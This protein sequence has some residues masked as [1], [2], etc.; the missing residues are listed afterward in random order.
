[1]ETSSKYA[2]RGALFGLVAA[3]STG[4]GQT[5]F[6]GLFGAE[7]RAEFAL[8]DASLGLMYGVATL[9]A[10]SMMFW[11]GGLAD[12][13][14]LSRAVTLSVLL[15]AGGALLVATAHAAAALI[16][17]L[18][19]LRLGGQG[20]TGHF[21]IVAAARYA[22]GARRGRGVA[23]ASLGF[24]L[25]EALYPILVVAALGIWDWRTV[26]LIVALVL[27]I[28]FVP[29]LRSIARPLPL[30]AAAPAASGPAVVD[31]TRGALLRSPTFL[32]AL[33]VVL[34]SPLLATAV[35]FH[36]AALGERLGW[37]ASSVA[38]AFMLF[39]ACQAGATIVSGRLIDIIGARALMRYYL[40]PLAL[41][42]MSL[43]TFAPATALWMLFAGIGF[44]AGANSVVA[45]A[46]WV[47]LFGSGQLGMIRG[48]YA[49]LMVISTAVSPA[50]LGALLSAD[51]SLT[52]I[53]VPAIAY[54]VIVPWLLA[55]MTRPA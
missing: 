31:W 35:F 34:V 15:V 11:L 18:F 12:R 32:G 50:I 42:L 55:P 28:I 22:S 25:S 21:A 52:A 30:P 46:V 13:L 4:A 48:V 29:V 16:V 2:R 39:A 33:G 27:A 19:L 37:S 7:F 17:G 5:F 14:A 20:L 44:T 9:A 43:F 53:F 51:F 24:I 3:A 10:G 36:Q 1:M 23:T 38:Y 47:E 40:L 45:G 41:G 49:A 6:I 54:I 26:W 8:T